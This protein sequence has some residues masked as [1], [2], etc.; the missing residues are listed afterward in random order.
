M[1][2]WRQN[3]LLMILVFVLFAA[4]GVLLVLVGDRAGRIIGLAT[5]AMFGV[6]GL[7]WWI[8]E[9]RT[10]RAAAPRLGTVIAR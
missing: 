9:F 8:G 1:M 6:G 10:E 3:R 5:L 2:S 4:A 7:A